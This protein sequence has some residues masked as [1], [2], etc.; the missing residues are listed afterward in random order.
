MAAR[1]ERLAAW[2]LS[3]VA[4]ERCHEDL[5]SAAPTGRVFGSHLSGTLLLPVGLFPGLED[6]LLVF[7]NNLFPKMGAHVDRTV[8]SPICITE[9]PTE[10]FSSESK[11]AV[12]VNGGDPITQLR[13]SLGSADLSS[14]KQSNKDLGAG[15][16]AIAR[17]DKI[18]NVTTNPL[19]ELVWS[20]RKGLSL[21]C[22]DC[23]LSGKSSSLLWSTESA[24]MMVL[25]PICSA[26]NIT[27]NSE[28]TERSLLQS[29]TNPGSEIP[30]YPSSA[31][32]AHNF[33]ATAPFSQ[34]TSCQR[35]CEV[36]GLGSKVSGA[37]INITEEIA[38]S[39]SRD[40][41]ATTQIWKGKTDKDVMPDTTVPGVSNRRGASFPMFR[42][43]EP[44]ASKVEAES[45]CV[46]PFGK[47]GEANAADKHM[48]SDTSPAAPVSEEENKHRASSVNSMKLKILERLEYRTES[49]VQTV[50][51]AASN[52]DADRDHGKVLPL[53]DKVLT[54]TLS[55]QNKDKGKSLCETEV[56]ES[57]SVALA[58][59][60]AVGTSSEVKIDKGKA[61]CDTEIEG[62]CSVELAEI[63]AK[64][65]SSKMNKGKG[66]ILCDTK[67]KGRYLEEKNEDP[68]SVES[69]NSG[70]I[71]SSKKRTCS[72][73]QHCVS[74]SK[75]IKRHTSSFINWISNMT[76]VLPKIDGENPSL[77]IAVRPTHSRDEIHHSL[78]PSNGRNQD[79]D[80]NR[81]GFENV[82]QALYG[83]SSRIEDER[84]GST[85]INDA[86]RVLSDTGSARMTIEINNKSYEHDIALNGISSNVQNTSPSG[87]RVSGNNTGDN[88][89]GCNRDGKI[90]KG[91]SPSKV[92]CGKILDSHDCKE[93]YN[94]IPVDAG[95]S[96][97][98]VTNKQTPMESLWI[99]RFT[100]KFSNSVQCNGNETPAVNTVSYSNHG[101]YLNEELNIVERPHGSPAEILTNR[102]D[103]DGQDGLEGGRTST[104]GSKQT[105]FDQ[106]FTSKLNPILPSQ[107]FKSSDRMAS[108]FARRLDA[109]RHITPSKQKDN[110][111]QKTSICFF[112]GANDHTLKDCSE[113]LESDLEDILKTLNFD[114][115]EDLLCL[116]IRCFQ[117]NHWAI[118]CPYASTRK[119]S[120]KQENKEI[121][122]QHIHNISSNV[123][124]H[125][126]NNSL[127]QPATSSTYLLEKK[128]RLTDIPVCAEG[129]R[130]NG[131]VSEDHEIK[132]SH[133][134]PFNTRE[135]PAAPRGIFDAIRQL[136]LSRTDIFRWTKSP[137]PS[138][139]LE[140]FYL[141]LHLGKWGEGF[142]GSGYHVACICGVAD[143]KSSES[144]Q[145]SIYVDVGGFK[146]LI[147]SRYISNQDFTEDELLA[148][149]RASLQGDGKLPSEK[150]LNMKLV[151]KRK[152][153]F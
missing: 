92:S 67:I 99:T 21:K 72:I 96:S 55:Q 108:I 95:R 79:G 66:K 151:E 56:K 118:A 88:S 52:E 148:W 94:L 115:R 16:N 70:G 39:L 15:A 107:R 152:I 13:L 68:E 19:S 57:Y 109:L 49:V 90:D 63:K 98:S 120:G 132:E 105:T 11:I 136:R 20:P 122:S 83:P 129:W 101:L 126:K 6:G 75:K 106:K 138:L 131:S 82:F 69:S 44:D 33:G 150:D 145:N 34:S 97:A 50:E 51:V 24:S 64:E 128:P 8:V 2:E 23:S 29:R 133:P 123:E 41:R 59:K 53:A 110:T 43:E 5:E 116:C 28:A 14:V 135:I 111:G 54:E 102:T 62:T 26:D 121:C 140:G 77:D 84:T 100:Q 60:I 36:M 25:P 143:E 89:N 9:H 22:A 27:A 144:C 7:W 71:T 119:A 86:R 153:G 17:V 48:P 117:L 46:H 35:A 38:P 4:S 85:K 142:G 45:R 73:D 65:T 37:D 124:G 58:D 47:N 91:R 112:C 127:Q 113:I 12:N 18:I 3:S 137:I 147:D 87:L 76:N 141:R 146:C 10:Q 74:E 32:L 125:K 80:C 93:A 149:W 30:E 31:K 134:I 104:C 114:N 139:R 42:Y 61:V 103:K 78:S 40:T 1:G 81:T 130:P